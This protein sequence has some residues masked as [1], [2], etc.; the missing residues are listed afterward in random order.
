MPSEFEYET[1]CD[2]ID[3]IIY[4]NLIDYKCM[5]CGKEREVDKEKVMVICPVCM[6]KMKMI[7]KEVDG[8]GRKN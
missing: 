4:G 5:K 2:E 1:E 8:D 7:N 6:E 3:E